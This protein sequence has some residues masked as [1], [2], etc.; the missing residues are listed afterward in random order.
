MRWG[1]KLAFGDLY[2][3]A[4]VC[5]VGRDEG[6]GL[7]EARLIACADP[8]VEVPCV[9]GEARDVRLHSLDEG[10]KGNRKQKWS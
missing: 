7:S 6:Q 8:I 4:K 10:V 1:P 2:P 9:Q 3:K 5:S